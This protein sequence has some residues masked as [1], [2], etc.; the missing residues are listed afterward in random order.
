MMLT[1]SREQTSDA[2][3]KREERMGEKSND[4][5]LVGDHATGPSWC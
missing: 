2:H 4:M 3:K 5:K 1:G